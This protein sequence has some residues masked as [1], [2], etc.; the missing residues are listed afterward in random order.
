[1]SERTQEC[2]HT[3]VRMIGL[4]SSER[5]STITED[6]LQE[7][8]LHR[9]KHQQLVAGHMRNLLLS[10]IKFFFVN[11]LKRDWHTLALIRAETDTACPPC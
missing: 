10:G 3:I 7:Y 6:E 5:P 8:L 9:K 2:Y 1:M 4:I 11:V